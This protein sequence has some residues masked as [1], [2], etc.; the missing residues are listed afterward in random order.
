MIAHPLAVA[1]A[2]LLLTA[3]GVPAVQAADAPAAK[4]KRQCFFASNVNS[5]SAPDED[6]VNVRVGVKDVYQL[7]L[8]TRCTDVD[9][10]HEIAIVSRGGSNICSGMDAT[11]VTK[12]P[13]GPQRCAVKTVRKL[14]PE[15]VAA[16]PSRAR[17]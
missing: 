17:P 11:I 14:S 8:L 1:S 16:L 2:A 9:W 15:E 6:T 4:P 13:F 12:G 3:V 5:F 7:A 10:N